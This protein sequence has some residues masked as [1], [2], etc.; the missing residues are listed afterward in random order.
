[1]LA[2]GR[3]DEDDAVPSLGG[4]DPRIIDPAVPL[5]SSSGW[6]CRKTVA[7]TP[8]PI[9]APAGTWTTC[10][11]TSEEVTS[12][13]PG[14]GSSQTDRGVEGV[15]AA[16]AADGLARGPRHVRPRPRGPHAPTARYG[17]AG[18]VL[19]RGVGHQRARGRV[20]GASAGARG[21]HPP[22]RRRTG[23]G[24]RRPGSNGDGEV[25]STR[26]SSS[27]GLVPTVAPVTHGRD[28]WIPRRV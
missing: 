18:R 4:L 22:C 16:R 17:P 28:R 7:V 25:G 11:G 6:K 26:G 21:A 27:A 10:C 3:L 12:R 20:H 5:A 8:P 1:M 23:R 15:P 24:A 2:E 19:V 14:G 9:L 13:T